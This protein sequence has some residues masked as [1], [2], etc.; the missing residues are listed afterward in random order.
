MP[1]HCHQSR[2]TALLIAAAAALGSGG[3]V[4]DD[5]T[6]MAESFK[7]VTP[8][9]AA[10]DMFNQDDPDVRRVGLTR[11]SNSPF[12]G[13]EPYVQAYRDFV[14]N[15]TDP[16]VR[17]VAIQAL[18]R[19]GTSG[20]A[21]L[22]ASILA[23]PE[24]TDE[25]LRWSAALGLQ[26]LHNVAVIRILLD[27]LLDDLAATQ[28]RSAIARGLGQYKEDRV[29]RGLLVVLAAPDLAVNVSAR[30]SLE[31]LTGKDF[32]L[33]ALAWQQWYDGVLSKRGQP[34][35]RGVKYVY[36]T[37]RRDL[38]WFEHLTFW[39]TPVWEHPAPPIG[40]SWSVARRTYDDVAAE[41]AAP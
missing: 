5:F 39:D 9:E 27:T 32:G 35:E 15:E 22:I 34:F 24:I 31:I 25:K 26:R 12:G 29:M 8:S 28:V 3:C 21:V 30:E 19:H 2:I 10:R 20:D 17:A 41:Q 6:D 16:V 4:F 18:A 13:G 37:Y 7:Q 23:D 36:P 33:D 11:L 14:A 38:V 1:S 40:S